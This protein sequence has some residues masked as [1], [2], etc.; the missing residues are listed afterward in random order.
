[1]YYL[2]GYNLLFVLA[3]SKRPL[4]S[5]RHSIILFLQK[6]FADRSL[7]GLLIFDGA[8]KLDETS[9]RS[10]ASPLEIIYTRAEESADSYILERVELS[11]NPAQITV[12]TDDAALSRNVRASGAKTMKN[13]PFIQWLVKRKKKKSSEKLAPKESKRHFERLLK[14]FEERKDKSDSE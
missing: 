7:S 6:Q 9:G 12:V 2:D 8:S 14:I 5:Q 10:Y 11:K 13:R 1:L 4:A 3:E